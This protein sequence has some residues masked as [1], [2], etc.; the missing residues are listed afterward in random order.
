MPTAAEMELIR[1]LR[2]R[3]KAGRPKR[4]SLTVGIDPTDRSLLDDEAKAR[5]TTAR[6]LAGKVLKVVTRDRLFDAVLD[7]D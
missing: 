5:G 2:P 1:G 7:G 4:A 3:R 6:T